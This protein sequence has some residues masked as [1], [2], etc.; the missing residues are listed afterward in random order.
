MS[1]DE[2]IANDV[3]AN[4][5]IYSL[6]IRH[7]FLIPHSDFVILNNVTIISIYI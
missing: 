4:L 6:V 7:S 1:N 3:R 2:T 5:D